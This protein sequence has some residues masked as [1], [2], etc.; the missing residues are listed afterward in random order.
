MNAD[1]LRELAL[2]VTFE[3]F[4]TRLLK[5]RQTNDGA[6]ATLICWHK[7]V[8]DG[9]YAVRVPIVPVDWVTF[10]DRTANGY[11]KARV[12][13]PAKVRDDLMIKRKVERLGRY[14]VME[15]AYKTRWAEY[16]A[17][18]IAE[19]AKGEDIPDEI[20]PDN[21]GYVFECY[22]S[23][24]AGKSWRPDNRPFWEG[25]DVELDGEQVQIKAQNAEY[26]NAHSA[27]KCMNEKGL[28]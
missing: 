27:L 3:D 8:G 25:G 1:K 18:R 6:T 19:G 26:Y 14:S 24:R 22:W 5:V 13:I 16:R 10:N 7:K 9:A 4:R 21:E 2:E 15:R 11:R 28:L 17:E 20:A 23:T 12:N